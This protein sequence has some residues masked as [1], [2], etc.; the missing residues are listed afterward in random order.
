MVDSGEISTPPNVSRFVKNR[1][2]F[3]TKADKLDT[4]AAAF[5]LTSVSLML[6]TI[7]VDASGSA[8][9]AV[10]CALMALKFRFLA[11]AHLNGRI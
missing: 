4:I 3:M 1:G 10:I 5:A 7:F 2:E 11:S 8:Y 6:S 9:V